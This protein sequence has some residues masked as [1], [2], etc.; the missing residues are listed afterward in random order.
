M[1]ILGGILNEAPVLQ[2]VLVLL[3]FFVARLKVFRKVT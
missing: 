2:T 3:D 1:H